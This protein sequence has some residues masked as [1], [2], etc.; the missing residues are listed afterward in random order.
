MNAAGQR[1]DEPDHRGADEE[2][3]LGEER[4]DRRARLRASRNPR[5]GSVG[6]C[7][8]APVRWNHRRGARSS[9]VSSSTVESRSERIISSPIV[10]VC[11]ASAALTAGLERTSVSSRSNS[12]PFSRFSAS[13]EVSLLFIASVEEA[14]GR[15]VL[16]RRADRG[17]E[18][19]AREHLAGHALDHVVLDQR[20]GDGLGQR[21]G[22]RPVDRG[23]G[24]RLE[25]VSGDGPRRAQDK[26]PGAH[27]EPSDAAYP[28]AVAARHAPSFTD[29]G[30]RAT[31]PPLSSCGPRRSRGRPRKPASPDSTERRSGRSRRARC[32]DPR[33][34]RDA[35]PARTS[36]PPFP[37]SGSF[38]IRG[39]GLTRSRRARA[40]R[41][42]AT[43]HGGAGSTVATPRA[44]S[45]GTGNPGDS[46]ILVFSG[47]P[48]PRCAV[49]P[50]NRC[51]GWRVLSAILGGSPHA[52]GF[53]PCSP[54]FLA[55]T[56]PSFVLTRS[57][58]REAVSL[59][60]NGHCASRAQVVFSSQARPRP[61]QPDR[62]PA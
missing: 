43:H 19:G 25:H 58:L 13:W 11:F 28:V 27:P 54:T 8:G 41:R 53:D 60:P 35:P 14:L 37:Y 44:G 16:E 26:A 57:T 15:L 36:V 42:N 62:H 31:T 9:R 24:D 21:A 45:S 38:S 20:A 55:S 30:R 5:T 7:P 51:C 18:V 2:E 6:S 17:L 3:R 56:L 23:L 39:F 52:H 50:Y 49:S 48:N 10:V 12:G 1:G 46:A 47:D 29:A 61:P 22:E 33:R 59:G 4:V 34:S 40:H 32:R